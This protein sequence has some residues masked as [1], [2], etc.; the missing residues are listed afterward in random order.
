[1]MLKPLT[2]MICATPYTDCEDRINRMVFTLPDEFGY[3]PVYD[4]KGCERYGVA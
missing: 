3:P 1:M 4:L 2:K